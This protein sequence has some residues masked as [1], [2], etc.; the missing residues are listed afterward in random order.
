MLSRAKNAQKKSSRRS[1]AFAV[2]NYRYLLCSS[3]L[4]CK[5]CKAS[6]TNKHWWM[7]GN[8]VPYHVLSFFQN[9]SYCPHFYFRYASPWRRLRTRR[10]LAASEPVAYRLV[11]VCVSQKYEVAQNSEKI[12]TYS[13]SRSSLVPIENT[14]ATSY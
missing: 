13:S 3:Q 6:I 1:R 5:H 14:Y 8:C 11:K 4:I 7:C 12:W 10:V 2:C 9:S